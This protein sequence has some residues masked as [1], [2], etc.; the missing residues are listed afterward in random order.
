MNLFSL[1]SIIFLLNVVKNEK[2]SVPPNYIINLSSNWTLSNKN[3]NIT[4]NNLELP[5]SVTTALRRENLIPDP[6]YRY[7]DVYLRWIVQDDNWIFSNNFKI[8]NFDSLN[9]S[10]T[11]NLIFDTID[12]IAS[13]YLN[14]KFILAGNN[15]FLKYHAKGL[16]SKLNTDVNTLVVK[17]ASPINQAK[18]LASTYPYY[19]PNNCT[20]DVQHGECHVNFLRKEQCSFSWDWGKNIIIVMLILNLF[21]HII[22]NR[23][24]F[25]SH[26]FRQCQSEYNKSI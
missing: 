6:L 17:F 2:E 19:V 13:V 21:I 20:P 22:I 25:C 23:S 5:I 9:D 3:F 12:T 24:S 11:I 1:I 7:N 18:M 26:L 14:E 15:Q 8:E 16:N 4:I 10:T